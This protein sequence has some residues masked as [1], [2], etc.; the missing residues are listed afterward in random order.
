MDI[1]SYSNRTIIKCRLMLSYCQLKA[2]NV[3]RIS[4]KNTI[5]NVLV[6]LFTTN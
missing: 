6:S 5:K 1:D 2:G 3:I 4:F